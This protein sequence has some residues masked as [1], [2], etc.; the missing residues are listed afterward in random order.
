MNKIQL[1]SAAI[2]ACY[3]TNMPDESDRQF[4]EIFPITK[5]KTPQD[6]AAQEKAEVKRMRKAHKKITA[7]K[8]ACLRK[9][10]KPNISFS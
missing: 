1:V 9:V 10:I 8:I 4:A 7:A 2:A 6:L 3:G 5:S